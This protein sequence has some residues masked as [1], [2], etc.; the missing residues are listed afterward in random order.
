M[1]VSN[2]NKI[3]GNNLHKMA[4]DNILATMIANIVCMEVNTYGWGTIKRNS[5]RN[6]DIYKYA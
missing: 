6:S 2:G 5:S 4:V 1:T 3:I